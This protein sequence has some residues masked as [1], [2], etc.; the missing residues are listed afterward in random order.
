MAKFYVNAS[1][2]A[3][4]DNYKDG[5][6][7]TPDWSNEQEGIFEAENELEALKDMAE[8][9]LGMP[10]KADELYISQG[11][12]LVEVVKMTDEHGEELTTE[13]FAA[14]QK[15]KKVAY[16][17]YVYMEIGT[18]TIHNADSIEALKDLERY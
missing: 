3:Y 2:E 14:W 8:M 13:Q 6:A 11:S 10:V 16:N 1:L 9:L 7:H 5:E 18:I 4:R 17:V 15:G 12:G